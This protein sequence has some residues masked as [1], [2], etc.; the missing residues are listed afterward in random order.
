[1]EIGAR[2]R[3]AREAQNLSLDH[4]QETT[5]IQKRYLTAIEEGNLHILPGKFYARAF[6]KE[7]AN[8]VG[9]DPNELLDEHKEEVPE[10]EEENTVQYTRMQ[11]SRK[12]SSDKGPAIFSI[13]PSIITVALVIGIF[14][15]AWF[16]IQE[17]MSGE[18]T[19]PVEEPNDNVVINNPDDE[20]ES[21]DAGTEADRGSDDSNTDNQGTGEDDGSED[22]SQEEQ[23]EP[24][25]NV[26]E[27]G[28]GSP[29]LSQI[30]FT[31]AGEQ[32]TL[33]LNAVGTGSWL[34]VRGGNNDEIIYSGTLTEENGEM[35][36]DVTGQDELSFNIGYTP[37]LE[38]AFNGTKLEY[39]VDPEEKDH[40]R[41]QVSIQ[42]QTGGEE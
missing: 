2:L 8:A 14:F 34:E 7:Y 26:I 6:I 10:T 36:F 11:R 30:E 17:A 33:S 42:S 40:Q 21:K 35:E 37:N 22:D 32:V 23:A 4:L 39:P 38:I 41:I 13:L 19:E 16:F 29:P 3:E 27:E 31:N 20:D 9:L 12:E 15:A 28:T 24:V 5:K 1:M 18:S 25:F